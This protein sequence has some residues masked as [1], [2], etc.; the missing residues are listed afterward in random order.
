MISVQVTP[1]E[2]NQIMSIHISKIELNQYL[3][4]LFCGWAQ[5]GT[6]ILLLKRTAVISTWALCA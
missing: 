6:L 3:K 4:I 1:I 2:I 5:L